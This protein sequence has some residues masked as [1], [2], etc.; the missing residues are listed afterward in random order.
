[1]NESGLKTDKSLLD[2]RQRRVVER[3]LASSPD[4]TGYM[5]GRLDLTEEEYRSK[6]KESI[7]TL[8]TRS[9]KYISDTCNKVSRDV[10]EQRFRLP[11]EAEIK[12]SILA[13][14]EGY[15]DNEK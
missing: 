2:N 9:N 13:I 12:R 8:E 4:N 1:M 3:M 6:N 7:E 14:P 5:V 11:E 15:K 10:E